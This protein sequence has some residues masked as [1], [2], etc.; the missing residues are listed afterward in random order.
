MKIIL[1][2]ACGKMG[3]TITE[4]CRDRGENIVYGVDVNPAPMPYPVGGL[5]KAPEADVLID[6]SSHEGIAERLAWCADKHIPAVLG[7]TGYSGEEV[8]VIRNYAEK[9][10]LFQSGNMSVGINLLQILVRKAAA[11]L[12]GFDVE[13]I[14]KHHNQK[15]DAPSGTAL[16][17]ARSVEEGSAAQNGRVYG[18]HGIGQSREKGE[19][20]IHA[21]RGGNIV[22]E[23]EVLFAGE[24]EIVTLSHSARSRSVFASG[25]LTAAAWLIRQPNGLYNMDDLLGSVL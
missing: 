18:R 16:M 19:I 4:L 5:S 1:C 23:H 24:D 21:V 11:V 25:A 3:R 6:F 12:Q 22:G 14:E 8:A 2:G 7:A 20:G 17:L 13:I 9:I 10:P 15:K